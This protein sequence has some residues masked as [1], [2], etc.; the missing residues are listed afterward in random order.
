MKRFHR[1]CRCRRSGSCCGGR[2]R[3]WNWI[4]GQFVVCGTKAITTLTGPVVGAD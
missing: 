4:T 1:R 3:C 2:R